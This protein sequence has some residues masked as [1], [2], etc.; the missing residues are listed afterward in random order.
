M[1]W[2]LRAGTGEQALATRPGTVTTLYSIPSP[3]ACKVQP[4]RVQSSLSCA[5]RYDS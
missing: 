2:S 3:R 5:C 4:L 1:A